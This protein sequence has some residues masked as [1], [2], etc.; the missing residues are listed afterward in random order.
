MSL[1]D[2]IVL[3]GTAAVEAAAKN[4]GY[5][6]EVAFTPGRVDASQE[7]T[8]VDSFAALEPTVGRVPQLPTGRA[9]GCRPSTSCS[10]RRTC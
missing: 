2:L 6:V 10:T 8:D 5:D 1:A 7:Q 4:A 3:A 9:T